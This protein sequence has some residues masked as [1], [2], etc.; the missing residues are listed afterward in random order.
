MKVY[1]IYDYI[2]W[3]RNNK[4]ENTGKYRNPRKKIFKMGLKLKYDELTQSEKEETELGKW[5]NENPNIDNKIKKY[6][7]AD[8]TKM[9]R[10]YKNIRLKPIKHQEKIIN[11]DVYL[12]WIK[13]HINKETGKITKPTQFIYRNGK[14]LKNVNEM[15]EED[16]FQIDL[17]YWWLRNS[18]EKYVLKK[19]KDYDL[20]DIPERDREVVKKYRD[21]INIAKEFQ[22]KENKKIE[23]FDTEKYNMY[24]EWKKQ[25]KIEQYVGY[26]EPRHVILNSNGEA[27]KIEEMT[28]KEKIEYEI[29]K[30]WHN[31][32]LERKILEK[33]RYI[34]NIE[35][36]NLSNDEKRV[37]IDYYN[38]G[39]KD[40][41]NIIERMK[42]NYKI[43]SKKEENDLED[44]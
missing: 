17:Y 30:W 4:D 32:P 23:E 19:Y 28:E 14:F 37:I 25:H 16:K 21:I 8:I 10:R 3:K 6:A 22:P 39:I 42:I 11:Y 5:L 44:R 36:D 41:N 2:N 13:Q 15:T 20:E 33:Y 40:V 38:S 9:K 34:T 31:K 24:L 1:R 7:N 12:E 29:G 43:N 26:K 35:F 27:K 18:N